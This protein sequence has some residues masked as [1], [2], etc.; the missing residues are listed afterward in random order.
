MKNK[1]VW[2]T[3]MSLIIAAWVSIKGYRYIIGRN[4]LIKTVKSIYQNQPS[5][6]TPGYSDEIVEL[7]RNLYFDKILSGNRN[8]SCSSC[9]STQMGLGDG[10]SVSFGEDSNREGGRRVRHGARLTSRNAQPLFNLDQRQSFFWDGRV[11][12]FFDLENKGSKERSNFF[13]ITHAP[14]EETI[15]R[16]PFYIH[17]TANL[18]RPLAAQAL[19]PIVDFAE[20]RGAPGS[21]EFSQAKVADDVWSKIVERVKGIEGYRQ[22]LSQ[23]YPEIPMEQINI[24]HI[25]SAIAIFIETKLKSAESIEQRI[26]TEWFSE[27]AIQGGQLFFGKASCVQCHSGNYFTDEK[28][29]AKAVPQVGP[30]QRTYMADQEPILKRGKSLNTLDD[31][32]RE[33]VTRERNDR[34]KFKTPSLLEVKFTAPYMHDGVY[35]ELIDA[36][37]QCADPINSLNKIKLEDMGNDEIRMM[38]FAQNQPQNE[39]RVAAYKNQNLKSTDLSESDLKK[40]ESFLSEVLSN[41][42]TQSQIQFLVPEKVPSN[43]TI[44]P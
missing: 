1:K 43:L 31:L 25:T 37:R 5:S 17:I 23:A 7:G 32:G 9:H 36:I 29:W 19:I 24:A 34:Y 28:F 3:I 11:E 27:D 16:T 21:N 10:L 4:N 6:R 33:Q 20:M 14:V 39:D 2:L 13:Y 40:I 30:G 41:P 42:K 38:N 22:L 18:L 26:Q 8:I 15:G 35:T 12:V 44:D